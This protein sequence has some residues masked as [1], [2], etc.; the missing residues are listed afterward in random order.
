MPILLELKKDPGIPNLYPYK[1]QLLKQL[2]DRKERLED[3]K[4]RQKEQRRREQ[5]KRRSLQSLQRDAAKR[6]KQYEKKVHRSHMMCYR[7][8]C[9]RNRSRN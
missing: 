6:T 7:K 4:Q 9:H 5:I 2:Q 8:C 3:E 1:E